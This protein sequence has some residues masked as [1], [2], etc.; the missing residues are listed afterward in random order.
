MSEIPKGWQDFLREQFPE[1]S[2]ITVR[3]M[4]NDPNP[5]EPGT[6]GTLEHID[7]TG[8]FHVKFD[9]GRELGLL[10]GTDSFT[11]QQPPTQTLKLYMPIVVDCFEPDEWGNWEEDP[12]RL[13]S[14][15]S[16][17]YGPQIF[18]ALRQE[19]MPEEAERGLMIYYHE[20]DAVNRKV[21]SCVFTGEVR[22]GQMW[23]VAEC[24]VQGQLA[25]EELET[26]MDYVTGQA[27]DGFGEV[28]EQHSIVNSRDAEVYAHLWNDGGEWSIMT[29][30]DRFDPLFHERLPDLC[31]SVLPSDGTLIYIKQGES[32]YHLSEDNSKNPE[33]NR[34][35]AD[36]RNRCRGISKAQ[37][38]AMSFGSMFGWDKPGADPKV[39][40][41]QPEQ[42]QGG[43]T[44]A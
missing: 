38:E 39:Y 25:P 12:L 16:V 18:A 11:V 44:F 20:D 5:V 26:L 37:E 33:Q 6:Q 17:E 9:S 14:H 32:G 8:T 3:E 24:R 31:W 15:D 23:G 42:K 34:H 29:E 13:D 1:G 7:D 30:Q 36:Y 22:D 21:Q 27:S 10:L 35:M 4:K 43:M 28:F 19:R 2:R 40:M 41:Q